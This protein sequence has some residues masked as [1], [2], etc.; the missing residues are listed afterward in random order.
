M[1]ASSQS[2]GQL[3]WLLNSYAEQSHIP[4]FKLSASS[5]DTSA[6]NASNYRFSL[7]PQHSFIASAILSLIE[8]DGSNGEFT[9][10][11]Q[12]NQGKCFR[13]LWLTDDKLGLMMQYFE[14]SKLKRPSFCR[15]SVSTTNSFC[16]KLIK[17]IQ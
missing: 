13:T 10:F 8:A 5:D 11:Y 2:S 12:H 17:Q 7:Y 15:S 14:L 9:I 16:K 4:F 1:F 6:F 3:S